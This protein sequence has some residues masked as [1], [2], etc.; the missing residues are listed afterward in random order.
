[1]AA[2]NESLLWG[3]YRPNL[4]FGVRP[5]LPESL[6]TGLIWFG[7]ENI[8]SFDQI[9]HACD[10]GDELDEYSFKKHDGRNFAI[11]TLSD[12]ENNIKLKTEFLKNSEGGHG[13]EWAVRIS[14][15]PINENEPSETSFL[16]YFG[17]E[18]DGS[19]ELVNPLNKMGL[20]NPVELEGETPDLGQFS[21]ILKDDPN[22]KVSSNVPPGTSPLTD[23]SKIQYWGHLVPDG[24]VWRARELLQ[25]QLITKYQKIVNDPQAKSLP[26]PQY[27]FTLNNEVKKDSNFFIFQKMVKGSFQFDIF[28]QSKS[29]PI[30]LDSESLTSGLKSKSQEFDQRFEKT[31]GLR[32]KGFDDGQIYFAQTIMSNLIGGIGYFYGSSIVDRSFTD[33]DEDEEEFWTKYRKAAP[34]LTPPKALFT[35]T[36][37]RPFF[38]RGFYWDEGF[39]QL[40]IGKWDND[41]SL[42]IIR[43]WVSLIDNDGWVAREQILGEEARSK[44]PEEFQIQYPHYANPPTLLMAIKS[45][46][47]R[48]DN[49]DNKNIPYT[50]DIGELIFSDHILS[51]TDPTIISSRYISDKGLANDFLKKIYPKLKLNYKWFRRTQWGEIKEWGRRARSREAYRWRGRTP[52]HTLTSGLDDY[53]RP[54]PPHPAE[55]HVDLMCWVGFMARSLKEIAERLEEEDDFDDYAKEYKNIVANLNDLHWSEE[56]N[57]FC[58]LSVDEDEE[59]IFVCHKG[60]LSLLP[61]VLELL[62]N[63]SPKLGA[64]LDM[65]YNPNELW[66]KYGLRSLSKSD[67]FFHTGE[68]YWRGNVWINVN[69][70]VLSSLY[71]NYAVIE[72]PYKKK[73]KTIYKELRNNI[74]ENVYKEF[75]RTGYVWEQYSE[76]TGAGLRSH[77]FTGWT[78]TVTL[79][80]AEEY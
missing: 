7:I 4:Y 38:P 27:L 75:V 19:I 21:I 54:T 61:M 28:F 42:D 14:G 24:D 74:I 39:H 51:T 72:S 69:Y 36:P 63:D 20:D 44:V 80:M 29:S 35:A 6:L 70:L 49:M 25:N 56:H 3:T 78:S 11:Q 2:S 62:P 5:R 32:E 50:D 64:I 41:L 45:F 55:L 52:G 53:P 73:A 16:Y 22:N 57:A 31:F 77:P 8:S 9:R 60:Y 26:P 58:D 71:K 13:G 10:Q 43:H 34:E 59:S 15:T 47:L 33:S 65:I 23:L 30:H 46:I 12:S 17:L 48:V 67:K 66:S 18:G 79:I 40:L 68:D 76:N 1:M 37:S